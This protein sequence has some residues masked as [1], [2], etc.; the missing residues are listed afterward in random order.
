MSSF[1]SNSNNTVEVD[2]IQ[3]ETVMP[4]RVV[5]IPSKQPGAKTHVQF[6]IKITN[7]TA[8]PR[9]FLLFTARPEFF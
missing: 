9:N 2:R 3:F 8:N 5:Q 6:G 7:N 1:K 4:E